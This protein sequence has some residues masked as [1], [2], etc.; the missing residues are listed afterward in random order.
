MI[1]SQLSKEGDAATYLN[2]AQRHA[3]ISFIR[4]EA[5]NLR[6]IKKSYLRFWS[7]DTK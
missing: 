3:F 5:L 2:N 1:L 6:K 7:K 4:H